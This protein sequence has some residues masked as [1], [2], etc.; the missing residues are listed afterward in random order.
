MHLRTI[1]RDFQTKVCGQVRLESEGIE[2]FRVFTPFMFDDGDNLAVVMRREAERW[3]LTD[4]AHTYMHLSYDMSEKDLNT[5]TRQKIIADTLSMFQVE[6]R[7]G[8]L[9]LEVPE[10]NFGDALFSFVQ[11]ILRISNVSFLARERVRS[12]F[13][14]DFRT[15][16]SE[17]VR[18]DRLN[19]NWSDPNHDPAGNYKV[20]CRINGT[21][22]PILVSALN[23]DGKT[24]DAT[25]SLLQF[26]KWNI[27]FRSLAIF[28]DQE[29]I[30]R[31]VLARFSD[32]CGK[33][34]SSLA[35]N[36]DR[37]TEYI[38]KVAPAA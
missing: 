5:G 37:I 16:L 36:R 29:A 7:E 4:E 8:E 33:Q 17:S 20:D 3:V 26:E 15:L 14:E 2:R 28:E 19:F 6:D 34:Y 18:K 35:P 30:N 25:I 11:A 13:M 23:N 12:T 31:K 32:V 1:E 38:S 9:R 10:E 21:D 24:R 27:P 22:R